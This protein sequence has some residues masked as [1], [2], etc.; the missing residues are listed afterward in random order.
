VEEEGEKEEEERREEEVEE[1]EDEEDGAA[2]P[3]VDP[4]A[5]D[6]DDMDARRSMADA[7]S[8]GVAARR[9][10]AAMEPERREDA[11]E[12]DVD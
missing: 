8:R 12:E 3:G 5:S 10:D 11:V 9:E 4:S 7:A 1:D 2:A 6:R